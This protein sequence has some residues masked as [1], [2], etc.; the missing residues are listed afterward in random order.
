MTSTL[1]LFSRYPQLEAHLQRAR[2]CSLPTPVE[3]KTVNVGASPTEVWI[4]RDDRTGTPYGGN[5]VRK[6]EFLLGRL[7]ERGRRRVATFG[8]V[9]SNHALAT[10]LYARQVGMEATCFLSHQT[11]TVLAAQALEAH[12]AIDSEIV[13]YGGDYRARLNTL[14]AHLWHRQAGVVPLGGSSWL[15]TV[16]FVN[17]G[18]ELCEQVNAGLLPAPERIYIAAG[19]MGSAAGLALGLRLGGIRAELQAVRVAHEIIANDRGLRRLAGK[20]ALMLSR[21]NGDPQLDPSSPP[22]VVWRH[23]YFAPGYARSNE[24]TDAAIDC[25]ARE[26]DLEL[27]PTYTGKAFAALLDDL[28]SGEARGRRL[29]FWNTYHSAP[30]PPMLRASVDAARLP[31]EFLRYVAG[32][33]STD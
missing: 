33:S 25:A 3:A 27:E 32:S 12:L 28:A 7:L 5:K 15:G 11:R 14:R 22:A 6:L 20:T 9:A 18:L 21:L 26:L 4:K 17:A 23:D 29:L 16:G 8:T 13:P 31:D 30:L 2:L 24:K 19:T 1:P 10:A